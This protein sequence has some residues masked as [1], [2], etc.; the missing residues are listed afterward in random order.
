MI[1]HLHKS[2]YCI[3]TVS[4]TANILFSF[5]L[6]CI[7]RHCYHILNKDDLYYK[8][9]SWSY[10]SWICNYLCNQC[11]SPLKLWVRNPLRGGVLNTTLCDKD[12]QWLA[13]GRW[14]SLGTP[15]SSTNKTDH[16]DITE[17]LLKVVL[18]T[19]TL[20]LVKKNLC[21]WWTLTPLVLIECGENTRTY[22]IQ[23]DAKLFFRR[24]V[25]KIYINKIFMPW[26]W[27]TYESIIS[28]YHH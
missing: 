21:V 16:N 24:F 13:A 3:N 25:P 17:I 6:S 12:C 14:F 8:L 18:N 22:S 5:K 7:E 2:N 20:T 11:L 27:S 23:P 9:G 28:A 15:V 1:W 19:I 4:T 10:D 26:S